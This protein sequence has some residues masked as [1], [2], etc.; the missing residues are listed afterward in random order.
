MDPKFLFN[1]IKNILTTPRSYWNTI[2]TEQTS[3]KV[4]RNSLI[5]PLIF[6]VSVAVITG[7]L[8]F[9]NTELSAVYSILQGI[10]SFVLLLAVVYSTSFILKEITYPLDLGRDFTIAFRLVAFSLV[11][12]L[13]CSIVSS[14][15]ESLLF[16]NI[17]GLYGLYVFWTG[18]IIFLNPPQHK[19]M[20]MLIATT[21]LLT[22]FYAI[23]D[24]VL[25]TITDRVFYAF[26]E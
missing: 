24:I 21:I 2:Q 3:E 18:A 5:L 9:I 25:S 13:L 15:F 19:R 8:I 1:S 12:F 22:A 17:L 14:V 6:I 11:P 23:F 4:I 20:P 16:I 26:F 10:K 7:S